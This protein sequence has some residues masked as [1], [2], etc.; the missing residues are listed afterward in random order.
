MCPQMYTR[1]EF[2]SIFINTATTSPYLTTECTICA[3]PYSSS[4]DGCA[5]TFSDKESC[6]H[7]FCKTCISQWLNTKG[8]NSC[9]LCRR[10]LFVLD[11][12]DYDGFDFD[13]EEED[14]EDEEE[15][16]QE[17]IFTHEQIMELLENA[18]YKVFWL[19]DSHRQNIARTAR[20]EEVESDDDDDDDEDL[21]SPRPP[22]YSSTLIHSFVGVLASRVNV[23]DL[24]DIVEFTSIT[25]MNVIACIMHRIMD[26]QVM[27][28]ERTGGRVK[29]LEFPLEMAL[30]WAAP[31]KW[32]M[33]RV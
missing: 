21:S 16:E 14:E 18:W 5:V 2:L 4:P 25:K 3:E 23:H 22:L 13:D 19:L 30:E 33:R 8:V 31:M 10:E 26:E 20:E 12:E 32:V 28:V 1:E 6:N 7:V 29:V 17:S 9:P 11:D 27:C 15:V 24:N